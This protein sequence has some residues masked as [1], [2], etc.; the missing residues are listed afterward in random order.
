MDTSGNNPTPMTMEQLYNAY[1]QLQQ[2]FSNAEAQVSNLHNELNATQ[3]EL[4]AAKNAM[5]SQ[6]PNSRSSLI[7]PKKPESFN[8]KSSVR[9][10]I[11]HVN[12][13]FDNEQNPQAITVAVIYLHGA[14]HEWL[15]GYKETEEGKQVTTWPQLQEAPIGRFE[16]LN[17]NKLARD[18]LAR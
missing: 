12:K 16:T 13:Y 18:K 1:Q 9:N 2:Q 10:R 8:G 7:K 11:T 15:L 4:F 5:Q 17:K 3:N 14:A 6:H